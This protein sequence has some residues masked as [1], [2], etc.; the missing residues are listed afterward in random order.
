MPTLSKIFRPF[1]EKHL[2]FLF[3]LTWRPA[4]VYIKFKESQQKLHKSN[5]SSYFNEKSKKYFS[6][7]KGNLHSLYD[8]HTDK[9]IMF[10]TLVSRKS[11][12]YQ[13]QFQCSK[14]FLIFQFS[15]HSQLSF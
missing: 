2:F 8:N 7:T 10:Y 9:K 13:N 11:G 12:C 4:I 5:F 3:G 6:S 1:T 14:Q 15:S